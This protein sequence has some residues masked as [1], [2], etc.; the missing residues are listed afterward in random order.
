[1]SNILQFKRVERPEP[2]A[3]GLA[4]CVDC[5][6]EWQAVVLAEHLRECGGWLECPSC[7][8]HKGRMA[9]PFTPNQGAQVWTCLCGSDFFH[10][11]G[12]GTLCPSCGSYQEFP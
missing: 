5:K 2:H 7:G 3:Q 10:I 4:K 12:D 1:M 8:I 6:H 9:W 11:L